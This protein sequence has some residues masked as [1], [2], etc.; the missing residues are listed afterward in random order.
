MNLS[1]DNE[2]TSVTLRNKNVH[3]FL[4]IGVYYLDSDTLADIFNFIKS[5]TTIESL[6]SLLEGYILRLQKGLGI[7]HD[8][9]LEAVV[10]HYVNLIERNVSAAKGIDHAFFYESVFL[11]IYKNSDIVAKNLMQMDRLGM[12]TNEIAEN[13]YKRCLS[14][15][16][17]P[18]TNPLCIYMKERLEKKSASNA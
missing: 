18:D 8:T 11:L 16:Q 15:F 6:N 10:A 1:G 3:N 4:K 9:T 12:M 17:C 2:L 5:I 13:I 14:Y 7:A